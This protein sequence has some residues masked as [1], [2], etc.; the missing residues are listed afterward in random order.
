MKALVT[1][2][3]LFVAG[4][5]SAKDFSAVSWSTILNSSKYTVQDVKVD[6]YSQGVQMDIMSKRLCTDG[7]FI[8]GTASFPQLNNKQ[9][10]LDLN[11]PWV[12]YELTQEIVSERIRVLP[13]SEDNNLQFE[14]VAYVQSPSVD[15]A[16]IDSNK[17]DSEGKMGA[18]AVLGYKNFTIARCPKVP[19]TKTN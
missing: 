8:Y 13:G 14:T 6:F 4:T 3:A 1:I 10:K 9:D 17:I 5:A 19:G 7:E 12:K 18:N 16:I 2:V 15:I 11:K